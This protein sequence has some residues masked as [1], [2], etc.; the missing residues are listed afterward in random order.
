MGK[1]LE[2]AIAAAKAA[3]QIMVDGWETD[4]AVK[5]KADN[6]LVTKIDSEAEEAI[7]EIVKGSFPDHKIVAEESGTSGEHGYC[8]YID[9]IDGTTNYSRRIPI[10]SVS[11]ALARD[12]Q[13]IA[14][15]IYIPFM[16][17]LYTAELGQGCYLNGTKV[18]TSSVATYAKA[19]ISVSYSH[20]EAIR[21]KVAKMDHL[22]TGNITKREYGSVA[23]EL[24][25]AASGRLDVCLNMGHSDWDYAAGCLLVREAGG[26]VTDFEG[27]AWG[28]GGK[29]LLAAGNSKLH[30]EVLQ[31]LAEF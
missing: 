29:K 9:P 22:I 28:L 12:G 21:E 25:L 6:S 20:D 15:V 3:G 17:E 23:Y 5:E 31:L 26:Q 19:V 16:N 24:A 30:Q 4:L 13:V 18:V 27:K 1:E 7:I 10:C 11:I 2:V 14:G 8:W